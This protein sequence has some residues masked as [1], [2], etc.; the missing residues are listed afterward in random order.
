MSKKSEAFIASLDKFINYYE[1]SKGTKPP[2]IKVKKKDRNL[3][4]PVMDGDFYRGVK[5][6]FVK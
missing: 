4:W 3:I 6:D 5:L 1:S 2:L